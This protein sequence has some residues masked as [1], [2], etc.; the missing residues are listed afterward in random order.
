M[1][2]FIY[3]GG[4]VYGM[5]GLLGEDGMVKDLGYRKFGRR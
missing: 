3:R 4:M 2:E 5:L 1:A